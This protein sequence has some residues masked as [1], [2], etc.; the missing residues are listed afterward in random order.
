ML[1]IVICLLD[2]GQIVCFKGVNFG[3][4]I[5]LVFYLSY[6][7]TINLKSDLKFIDKHYGHMK[8]IISLILFT[9]ILSTSL[10]ANDISLIDGQWGR[11]YVE[12][13]FLY[14]ILN[15][16]QSEIASSVVDGNGR[17]VF[18]FAPSQEGLYVVGTSPNAINRYVFYFKPGDK[19]NIKITEN[20]YELSGSNTP[21]NQEMT[22]WHDFV[23]PLERKAT[24]FMKEHST[25]VDFFPLLEEKLEAMTSYPKAATANAK[26]NEVFEEYK[27]YNM[28]YY[29]MTFLYTP[30]SAHPEGED[31]PDYYKSFNISDLSRTTNI[32]SFPDGLTTL[33]N[34]V[35]NNTNLDENI[36]VEKKQEII[37]NPIK[38]VLETNLDK[39]TDDVVKG[40]LVLL[41]STMNSSY[42]GLID[43]K[44]KY[45]KYLITESQKKRFAEV[46]G[47]LNDNT[48]GNEAIDFK[49]PDV[50]GKEI[51]LSDFKG[52]VV[53]IDVWATWCGPC[54]KEIPYLKKL[55]KEYH[56][57]KN[58]VFL[59]VSA[60]A[61]KDKEKWKKYIETEE[62]GG[63]Q[64]FAGD[65]AQKELMDLYKIK[66][67]PRFILVGKDGKLIAGEAPRPSSSE[68]K[69]LL[70][71]SLK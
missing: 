30:R 7:S 33:V 34:V 28:M 6:D 9:I 51:A 1:D 52:K 32:L 53:Y 67:I 57:N 55:E 42:V 22:K 66:G 8:K 25:Y 17:F 70:D 71:A 68:I 44:N 16:K 41:F 48:K 50:T 62:L 18:A 40:E 58:I 47:K 26:F 45:G 39:V 69:A 11:D 27:N 29:A 13:V 46:Q 24:Y 23:L 4:D 61:E 35:R 3:F 12:K 36:P 19:L 21:E 15:G 64:L 10:N 14:K 5:L 2:L 59:S 31:F 49:F 38:F 20:S 37:A 63:V 56:G 54:K 60:D 43:Y 65:R